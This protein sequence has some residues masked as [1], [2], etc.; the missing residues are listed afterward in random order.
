MR[1]DSALFTRVF[2]VGEPSGRPKE[3]ELTSSTKRLTQHASEIYPIVLIV[4]LAASQYAQYVWQYFTP[5][6]PTIRSHAPGVWGAWVV[7]MLA[8][9][10][11][12]FAPFR[13]PRNSWLNA[14]LVVSLIGW[15]ARFA[16]ARGHGDLLDLTI[17]LYPIILLML[18]AKFPAATQWRTILLAL[19]WTGSI[20][21][22][23]TRA[24]ELLGWIPMAPVSADLVRFEIGEYW[25]PLSG[26]LGP[27]G[28]W[29]GPLGGTAFTGALGALLLVLAFALRTKSSWVFGTVGAVVLLLTSSRG[30]IA[31]AG[32]GVAIAILFSN[33][34]LLE[35][36]GFLA[37]AALAGAG[38]LLV[39]A[40]VVRTNLTL[41]GRTNFWFDF[42]DLWLQSPVIG[43]GQTGYYEGTDATA[44]SGTAHSFYIDE[45]ARNGLIGLTL[46]AIGFVIAAVLAIRTAK[47]RAP[48]PLALL[49]TI[50]VLGIVN[51]PFGWLS[52]SLMWL[53]YV[54][55]VL[56]AGSILSAHDD[57][58]PTPSDTPN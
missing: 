44:V 12:L 18:W 24:S 8:G 46:L 31:G 30:S 48:G 4:G 26:T 51:T 38:G 16:I 39:I 36:F 13:I 27:E 5:A 2:G 9:I 52:P 11:W 33:W 53:F 20:L 45:L 25:L 21:L 40:V 22:V 41:T 14:F 56:W 34:R 6:L 42:L 15:T 28:R 47:V 58:R 50:A 29:P 23:W 10:V 3:V 7:V 49:T 35:R 32:A 57:P 55:P 1:G 19:G 43:V 54:L 37:R 17:W